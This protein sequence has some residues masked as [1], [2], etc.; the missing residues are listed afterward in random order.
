MQR[1]ARQKGFSLI[2]LLIVVA[3]ILI[4][5]SIAIPNL[6][7]ARISANES[8]AVGSIRTINTAMIQYMSTYPTVGYAATLSAL[9]GT[10]C[11]PPN[12]SSA[13]LIDSQLASGSKSGYNFSLSGVAGSPAAT[14]QV[15]GAPAVA[16]QTG[17]RYFCSFADGAVRSS[18]SPIAACD[19]TTTPLQ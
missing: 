19:Y 13:C 16:N 10:S 3:I 12:S 15:V 18:V 11:A 1:Q 5:A 8:S 9:G 7:R 6:L 2:E 14:Y 4:I 17:V